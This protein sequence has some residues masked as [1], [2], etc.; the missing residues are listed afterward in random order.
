MTVPKIKM[1]IVGLGHMG[2]YM[3]RLVQNVE[4]NQHIALIAICESNEQSRRECQ[5]QYP[6]LEYFADYET[7]LAESDLDL[8]YVAVPPAYHHDVVMAALEKRIHVFCEKPLANSLEEAKRMLDKA[9][10]VNVVHAIHFSLP[11]EPTMRTLKQKL[12]NDQIGVIRKIELVWRFPS[13][14]RSWQHNS[15]ISS[16]KQGGF[17]LEVGVHW[18]HVIQKLFGKVTH[19]QSELELSEQADCCEIGVEAKL[20][21]AD[22]TPVSINGMAGFAG[23]ERVSM[24]VH[25]TSGTLAIENWAQLLEGEIGQPLQV[26]VINEGTDHAVF[27]YV[28]QAI[29]GNMSPLFDFQDGYDAQVVLEALRHPASADWV[30]IREA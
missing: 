12:D 24:I 8:L 11:H 19:V 5:E 4:Y 18:I 29:K 27:H 23:E 15:W 17:V 9:K 21:L 22:G 1:A 7:L 25:G 3:I 26:S 10:E 14:P 28:L 13:W 6:E 20:R 30:D 2:H 16:R